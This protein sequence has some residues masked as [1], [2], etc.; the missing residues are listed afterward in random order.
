MVRALTSYWHYGTC[1]CS[2]EMTTLNGQDQF[3]GITSE[4]KKEEYTQPEYF[5][6]NTVATIA[7]PLKKSQHF[8][9]IINTDKVLIKEVN[10]GMTLDKAVS[11][12]FPSVTSK[13]FYFELLD[14]G[15]HAYVAISKK[16]YVDG[17]L[18]S[19]R[20]EKLHVVGFRL[21]FGSLQNLVPILKTERVATAKRYFQLENSQL[22]L[23]EASN[24]VEATF[25]I[26]GFQVEKQFVLPLAG[27]LNYD[28]A[29]ASDQLNYNDF[30]QELK[31]QYSET[32]FFR[33]GLILG[34]AVL[35]LL[36][37]TNFFFFSNY[38]KKHEL[39]KAEVM[40]LETKAEA[41]SANFEKVKLKEHRVE[42]IFSGGNSE[43]S[44]Y[45][46]RLVNS[47]PASVLF[48]QLQYQP[49]LKRIKND[50]KI[51]YTEDQIIV[52][53]ES[54][55]KALFSSWIENLERFDWIS[56]VTI[57]NYGLEGSKTDNFQISIQLADATE[58]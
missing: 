28:I 54:G 48:T 4:K 45:L 10:T 53:G 20:Q 56:E 21:G 50:K 49:L 31:S 16:D 8:R 3:F 29:T 55:D 11:V 58:N 46:N 30:N 39:L 37:V 33:K 40:M 13:S 22:S 7:E 5:K 1:F 52:G 24:E 43:S 26:G 35:L 32:N 2:I 14:T 44:L 47:K 42:N 12:A 51:S 34:V 25:E 38:Y 19:F 6:G 27:I 23:D 41:Y 18:E 57:L 15:S 36:L 17:I 9:L